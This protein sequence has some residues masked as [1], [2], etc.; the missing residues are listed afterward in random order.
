MQKS[1]VKKPVS[2]VLSLL[3]LLSLFA[4]LNVSAVTPPTTLCMHEYDS[5]YWGEGVVTNPT[6]VLKGYTTYTCRRC[7]ATK[8]ENYTPALGHVSNGNPVVTAPTAKEEGYTTYTCRVCGATWKDDYT[9]PTDAA[10]KIGDHVYYYD[11]FGKITIFG[12]GATYDYSYYQEP[13]SPF[14]NRENIFVAV[15]EDGVT[16]IG[17]A[18]FYNCTNLGAVTL[19]NT[20]SSI[21][22]ESFVCCKINELVIPSSVSSVGQFAFYYLKKA[23]FH[24]YNC[25]IDDDAFRDWYEYPDHVKTEIEGC[26]GSTAQAYA[27]KKGNTFNVIGHVATDDGRVTVQPTCFDKGIRVYT[28]SVCGEDY[29]VELPALNHEWETGWTFD[30]NSHW[31]KCIRCDEKNGTA[32]HS[33]VLVSET[34]PTCGVAGSRNYYCSVCNATWDVS[35]SATGKHTWD[36]GVKISAPTCTKMGETVY[37]CTVCGAKKTENPAAFGHSWDVPEYHWWLS[38]DGTWQCTATRICSRDSSH[39]ETET[40]TATGVVTAQPTCTETGWTTYTATFTNAAFDP[41]PLVVGDVPE[42]GH[43]EVIDEAVAPDC[44][45]TGLTEGKHCSV[46]GE[47]LVAQEVVPANGHTEVIDAAVAP[48]CTEPGLTEGKHCSV[49]DAVLV[50]Q[51]VVPANGHTEIIDTAVAPTCTETGLTEGKHCSV[52]ETVLVAQEVVPATGHTEII[53]TTVAPTCTETGLTE[54][55][56]CSVCNEVLVAQEV[57]PATGHTEVIDTAVAPTCTETGMTEGKHCSV[58]GEVLLAQEVVPANGHTVVIDAAVAA[59]CTETGLTEGKH[60]SVCGEVLVA[61]KVVPANVHTEVIDAAVA[62]TCTKTG[63][64]EGKHCSV[65]GGVLVAQ[66]PVAALGHTDA[67]GNGVCDRCGAETATHTETPT[68]ADTST[69]TETPKANNFFDFFLQ[70]FH[71]L[72]D[73]LKGIIIR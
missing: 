6:C 55:K 14:A 70:F 1:F 56:H 51:E 63:L 53:D 58:C 43:T 36:D 64:T 30:A 68:S 40:V 16:G 21:G 23:V 5:S 11:K 4:G 7:G 44:I 8:K 3:L 31:H 48:T 10:G 22:D 54:G 45:W 24:S 17:K 15:I 34:A 33:S 49:C 38:D 25:S 65:C 18:L 66:A 47:V 52:C 27:Q 46:C 29:Q 59:T 60:C 20:V 28:C 42:T 2:V 19:G 26:E 13:Y 37:T 12:T 71:M 69:S 67:D 50:A 35:I 62:P 39:V 73:F 9:A 32:K 61:Q 41:V 72:F 57:V